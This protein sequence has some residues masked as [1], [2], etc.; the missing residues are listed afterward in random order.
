MTVTCRRRRRRTRNLGSRSRRGSSGSSGSAGSTGTTGATGTTG[1]TGTTGSTGTIGTTGTTGSTGWC[2]REHAHEDVGASATGACVDYRLARANSVYRAG[3]RVDA[4]DA[5]LG[6][7][8]CDARQ[9]TVSGGVLDVGAERGAFAN[10]HRRLRNDAELE[11][12]MRRLRRPWSAALRRAVRGHRRI[13]RALRS[14]TLRRAPGRC[15]PGGGRD[16]S[17]ARRCLVTRLSHPRR[18][19]IGARGARRTGV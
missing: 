3:D 8:P 13:D 18:R 14:G 2:G 1:T 16:R 9:R 19:R 4:H 10:A 17:V 5:R 12:V 15:R 6:R 7:H 11:E